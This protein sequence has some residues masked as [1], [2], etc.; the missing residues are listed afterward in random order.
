MILKTSQIVSEILKNKNIDYELIFID[1]GSVDDT[2]IKIEEASRGN[3]KFMA[4]LF[5]EILVRKLQYMQD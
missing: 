4:F 5:Q 3:K 1:D 2:W